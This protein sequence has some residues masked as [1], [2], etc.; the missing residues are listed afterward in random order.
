MPTF[1]FPLL[2][3]P[4]LPVFFKLLV[5]P[6]AAAL[7]KASAFFDVFD[8]SAFGFLTNILVH[9]SGF[10]LLSSRLLKIWFGI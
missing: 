6:P 5:L 1:P 8:F 2:F 4:P 7:F 9:E 10:F 3:S